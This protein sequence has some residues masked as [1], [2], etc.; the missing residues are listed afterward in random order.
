[1]MINEK[2]LHKYGW[3]VC[4]ITCLKIKKKSSMSLED[5]FVSDVVVIIEC[6]LLYSR[7]TTCLITQHSEDHY[8]Q[9]RIMVKSNTHTT[10]LLEHVYDQ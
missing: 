7:E 6:P 3:W 10:K 9:Q 1:M 5:R 4:Y 8:Q 2:I